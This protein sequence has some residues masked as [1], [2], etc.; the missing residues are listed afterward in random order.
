MTLDQQ[1]HWGEGNKYAIEAVKVLLLLNGG[2]AIAL[3]TFIE[4]R[5]PVAAVKPVIAEALLSFG[6]GTASA[7]SVF[8]LAYLTQH[9]GNARASAPWWHYLTYVLVV[10]AVAGFII[11]IYFTRTAV[12]ASR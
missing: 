5:T 8:V 9:Y 1:W 6:V 2:G 10:A 3:L 4:N 11:G 12:I 7:A